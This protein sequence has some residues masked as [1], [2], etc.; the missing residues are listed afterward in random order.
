M[1]VDMK[2]IPAVA[3]IAHDMLFPYLFR[4]GLRLGH[5]RVLARRGHAVPQYLRPRRDPVSILLRDPGEQR[6]EGV[7]TI[8]QAHDIGRSEENTSE[9]QSIMRISYAV[10]S[11]NK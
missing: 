11:L 8:G 4:H 3:E 6:F 1:A 9:I 7:D 10:F 2:Q 5:R